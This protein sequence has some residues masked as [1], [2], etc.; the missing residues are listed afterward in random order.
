MSPFTLTAEALSSLSKNIGRTVLS[1]LGIVIG[2]ASV[3]AMMAVGT[4]TQKAVEE[5]MA[6]LGDDWI[7]VWYSGIRRGIVR[8]KG[9]ILPNMARDDARAVLDEC[10]KVRAV[11]L[12]HVFGGKQVVSAYGNHNAVIRGVDLPYWDIRKEEVVRGRGMVADDLGM[13]RKICWIGMTVVEKLFG[14]IDPIG[15][16]IR[17]DRHPIEVVGILKPKGSGFGGDDL[18]DTILMPLATVESLL[19]GKMPPHMFFAAVKRGHTIEAAREQITEL[20][21][22]RHYIG[23]NEE[24]PFGMWDRSEMAKMNSKM[25][26]TFKM[27]LTF[28]GSISLLV[29]GVGIMNIMLVSVTERTREIGVR[30]AIGAKGAHILSQFLFEAV[31]LCAIGGVLGFVLGWVLASFTAYSFMEDLTGGMAVECEVSYTMVAV[32]IGVSAAVGIF[33]GFYPAWRASRLNPIDALRYE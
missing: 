1:V 3:I 5:Q 19:A 23:E 6:S 29:G 7:V 4:G 2:I 25:T 13:R 33:F 24:E 14:T 30:M 27:L 15:Q 20:L 28:I 12:M 9:G 17:V 18:D 21:R 8:G 26:G 31:V 10:S 22:E 16:M 11:S 32:A